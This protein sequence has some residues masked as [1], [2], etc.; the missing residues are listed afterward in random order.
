MNKELLIE[1][2]VFDDGISALSVVDRE[3][4]EVL[5]MF[6]GDDAKEIYRMLTEK[7]IEKWQSKNP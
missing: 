7:G 5:N 3:K 6:N 2:E 4:D 1:Y